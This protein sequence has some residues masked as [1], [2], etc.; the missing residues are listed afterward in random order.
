MKL[1]LLPEEE[2]W[3]QIAPFKEPST[4]TATLGTSVEQTKFKLLPT[5]AVNGTLTELIL[6]EQSESPF[7][8]PFPLPT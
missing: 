4:A 3:G 5:T 7:M 2:A 8:I 6:I 1:T